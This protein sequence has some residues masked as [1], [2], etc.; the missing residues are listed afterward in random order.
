MMMREFGSRAPTET[1]QQ[2][3]C[4]AAVSIRGTAY[5]L[6]EL[7]PNHCE[8][9]DARLGQIV[10]ARPWA[11]STKPIRRVSRQLLV[12]AAI[13]AATCSIGSKVSAQQ[14]DLDIR[15]MP[16]SNRVAIELTAAPDSSWSFVDSYAGIVGL[17]RRIER[18]AAFDAGGGEVSLSQTA[19]G[20]FRSIRPA[21]RLRYE[22]NLK[23]VSR[24]A[25]F[26]M[27]SWLD[28]E[29]GVLMPLDLLPVRSGTARPGE[30]L[31]IHFQ[32]PAA[33]AVHSSELKVSQDEFAIADVG[34]AVFAVGNS[35]RVSQTEVAGLTLNF[36]SNGDWA[37]GDSD[38]LQLAQ[39]VLKAHR[40]TFGLFPVKTATFILFPFPLAVGA[41]QWSAETRGT[42]VT[43]IMG[44]LPS[45]VAA[46]AQLST[47]VTHEFFH[48]WIPNALPLEANYD[49][50][51]EGFTIYQ[52]AQ[53]AVKLGLLTFP[54]FLNSVARAYD[55]SKSETKL[56][57]IDASSRRFT[58][59][60]NSVYAKSQVVA[61]LYDLRLRCAS[62]N[63][64]S[65]ADV[66]RRLIKT[67][68]LNRGG[69]PTRAQDGSEVVASV[70]TQEIGSE[71]FVAFFVRK[72]V[73]INLAS[74]LA[75]FGLIAEVSGF[76]TQISISEKLNKQQ[77]DLLR[78]LGYNA[79]THAAR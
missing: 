5:Q 52:A 60:A 13:I 22:V 21:T 66:Y 43:L 20:Q 61:F 32:I 73:S 2:Q 67:V 71:D 47:P 10:Y 1:G 3:N 51:Y 12:G 77:R 31:K 27:I 39:Q 75:P 23:P 50:F 69:G 15:L 34:R 79:A 11:M 26:S 25:D 7:M 16:D 74:E 63:K 24:A 78:E 76:R 30:N 59:G 18:F 57:L 41:S 58:G 53:A 54:E 64:R 55:A 70:L 68:D 17:G 4:Q 19:P 36:V 8:R 29:R 35:L 37:F 38:V 65:L 44:K 49:W 46:L 62:H 33:W 14:T 28:K 9:F 42:T 40:E 6:V 45:R 56:S 48:L 72:P